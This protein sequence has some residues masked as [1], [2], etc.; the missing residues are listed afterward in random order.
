MRTHQLRLISCCHCAGTARKKETE[1]ARE[2]DRQGKAFCA[3]PKLSDFDSLLV[4]LLL[5]IVLLVVFSRLSQHD[6]ST[7]SATWNTNA[8]ATNQLLTRCFC[9]CLLYKYITCVYIFVSQRNQKTDT[10]LIYSVFSK[11]A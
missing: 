5:L 10:Q 1:R 2:A 3:S 7:S 9:F 8:F 4:V 6:D 11:H